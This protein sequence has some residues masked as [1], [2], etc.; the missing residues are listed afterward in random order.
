MLRQL[1]WTEVYLVGAS[2]LGAITRSQHQDVGHGA[3]RRQVLDGLRSEQHA[4]IA[5]Y[6]ASPVQRFSLLRACASAAC[7]WHPQTAKHA[8]QGPSRHRAATGATRQYGHLVGGAVLAEADGV[9][10]HD[11][12]D[13]RLRQR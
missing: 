1:T 2:G 8:S 7:S 4:V 10:R 3:E 13:A 11:V 12:D 5:V 6:V 9:V